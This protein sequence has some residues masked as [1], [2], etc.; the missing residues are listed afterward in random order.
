MVEGEI[1]L[2]LTLAKP[3]YESYKSL[4]AQFKG[5]CVRIVYEAGHGGFDL[6]DRLTA[7]IIE[8]ILPR[9]P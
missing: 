9:H 3:S 2:A 7:D 1:I 5:T 4:L 6:Y 8:C